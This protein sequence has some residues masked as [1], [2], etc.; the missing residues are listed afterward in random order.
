MIAIFPIKRRPEACTRANAIKPFSNSRPPALLKP[1]T[2]ALLRV[3]HRFRRLQYC[4]IAE[5]FMDYS[6]SSPIG[7]S[8]NIISKTILGEYARAIEVARTNGVISAAYLFRLTSIISNRVTLTVRLK[9][10]LR[11]ALKQYKI[12]GWTTGLGKINVDCHWLESVTPCAPPFTTPNRKHLVER[13]ETIFWAKGNFLPGKG[14]KLRGKETLYLSETE[15]STR[16]LPLTRSSIFL[17][18]GRTCLVHEC[19]PQRAA[20]IIQRKKSAAA[21][22]S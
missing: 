18:R 13:K 5:G 11:D 12:A 3:P 16:L 17:S 9:L 4:L 10:R 20:T 2:N 15:A 7:P 8:T 14:N 19:G 1:A 21:L 6:P 22:S